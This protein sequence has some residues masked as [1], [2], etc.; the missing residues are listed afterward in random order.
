LGAKQEAGCNLLKSREIEE[1]L[2]ARAR[3]IL[4]T[5]I[6]QYIRTAEPVG[7]PHLARQHR[8]NLSPASIRNTLGTLERLGYL[9]QPHT[10]AGRVPTDRGYRFYVDTLM[11]FYTLSESM[12]NRIRHQV[13]SDSHDIDEILSQA[14]HVLGLVSRQLGVTLSPRFQKGIFQRMEMV[15]LSEKRVLLVLTIKSGLVKTVFMEVGT[16]I[17]EHKLQETCRLLNER[18]CDLTIQEIRETLPKRVRDVSSAD[19]KLLQY[20]IDSVHLFFDFPQGGQLHFAGTVNIV[21][22]PEFQDP[23]KLMKLMGLLE[24]EKTLGELLSQRVGEGVSVTIGSENAHGEMRQYSLLTTRYHVGKVEG[25]IGVIGP[26]RMRYARLCA[27]VEYM[28]RLLEYIW[29]E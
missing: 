25:T 10:S 8:L 11:P 21:N 23:I 26:T 16:S 2:N 12:K 15:P 29:E 4:E 20:I 7:S 24:E 1:T 5:V 3:R 22:Q 6:H 13:R 18:L 28:A 14:S 19:P 9:Y 27:V 17:P